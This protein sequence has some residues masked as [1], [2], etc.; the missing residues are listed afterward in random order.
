MSRVIDELRFIP[1]ARSADFERSRQPPTRIV[2]YAKEYADLDPRSTG[3]L[4]RKVS[5]WTAWTWA[6]RRRWRVVEL[7]EP[8]W[9]R[10]LPFTFSIG[11]AL[12][13]ADLILGH[14]V[15]I[16]TYA[17]E[18]NAPKRLFRP[19]PGPVRLV[20]AAMIRTAGRVVYDNIAFA[21]PAAAACYHAAHVLPS[22]VSRRVF[23]ELQPRCD[24]AVRKCEEGTVVFLGALAARKGL[25]DLLAAWETLPTEN[26][27]WI[28]RIAGTGPCGDQVR[29][30]A[31]SDPSIHYLGA[32]DREEVHAV[33]R[34]AAV[35]VLPSRREGR[36]CEQIGLPI[37]EGLAH[38]CRIVATPDT[39]LAPW[40]REHGHLVLLDDF[41]ARDL[42][43]LLSEA[44]HSTPTKLDRLTDHLPVADA[45]VL[46]EDWMRASDTPNPDHVPSAVGVHRSAKEPWERA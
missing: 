8:L 2:L 42:A 19:L 21:S 39:G 29:R 23:L 40:L 36:W 20:I 6:F 32:V 41:T 37:V 5:V 12:R 27:G 13:I 28:L 14:R 34:G 44:L 45:R 38:G 24:C 43:N 9:L 18:N 31:E 30:A 16:V 10:A 7:P 4:A 35:L 15:R 33:L 11:L 46:A 25:P 3:S 26:H 22:S 17:M 1:E